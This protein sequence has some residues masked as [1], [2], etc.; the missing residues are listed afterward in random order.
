MARGTQGAQRVR[1]KV[2]KNVL[3]DMANEM[4]AA[5]ATSA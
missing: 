1:K 2:K 4:L 5:E 3:R